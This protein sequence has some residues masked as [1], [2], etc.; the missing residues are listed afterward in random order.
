MIKVPAFL[1][2][3]SEL[4]L[5]NLWGSQGT[6]LRLEQRIISLWVFWGMKMAGK[7][8]WVLGLELWP[9]FWEGFGFGK[10]DCEGVIIDPLWS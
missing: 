7:L 10:M 2:V 3:W 9:W 5:M 1:P 6:L 4:K 8:K